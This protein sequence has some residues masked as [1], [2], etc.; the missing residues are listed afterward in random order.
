MTW[1]VLLF[2]AAFA[3]LYYIER[4]RLRAFMEK[5]LEYHFEFSAEELFEGELL[6]LDQVVVNTTGRSIPFLKTETLLPQGL[7]IVL[8]R[9]EGSDTLVQSVQSVFL[10]KPYSS[11]SRRW[12]IQ[13]IKRGSYHALQVQMHA[14]TNDALGQEANSRRLMPVSGAHDHLLVLPCARE[15]LTRMALSPTLIGE[16]T[17][18]RGLIRDPMVTRGVR[19]WES[20]DPL[21]TVDWK[22]T[23]RLGRMVVREQEYQQNDSYNIV[24]NMQSALIEPNP[25]AISSP[26]YIEDCISVCASLLDSAVRRD[27]PVSLIANT[28]PEG[29][30]GG[31]LRDD[32]LGEHMYCSE[33]FRRADQVMQAFRALALLPMVMSIPVEQMLDD[34]I[35]HPHSYARGGHIL[36]VTTYLNERMLSFHRAL[37]E[38]GIKVIFYIVGSGLNAASIPPD[39]EVYYKTGEWR[40][41]VWY[42][43]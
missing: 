12:R 13:T 6:Y 1:L 40:G 29:L 36:F 23:A 14:I 19:D 38:E 3:I 10:L 34:I 42:A 28:E 16:Q 20:G 27:I 17:V 8:G 41:G 33:E 32:V 18:P 37:R 7:K 4:R 25:P 22:Q 43:S 5:A 39:V 2:I 21:N 24:L 15:W 35:R 26:Y 31:R 9:E 30:P 11:V